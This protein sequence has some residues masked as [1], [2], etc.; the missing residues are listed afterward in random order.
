[1]I[2]E[3]RALCPP[4]SAASRQAAR[5][6]VHEIARP[7]CAV[8]RRGRSGGN[9]F[10]P[11]NNS[12]RKSPCD[13][14]GATSRVI[15]VRFSGVVF[16]RR[17]SRAKRGQTACRSIALKRFRVAACGARLGYHTSNQFS[18]A[19]AAEGTPH[20]GNRIE[21]IR[22]PPSRR[23]GL[24]GCT[25]MILRQDRG[26]G[27]EWSSRMRLAPRLL[28]ATNPWDRSDLLPLETTA[29]V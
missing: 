24:P 20:G 10:R 1:M 23:R 5:V 17:D 11:R 7:R 16:S 3:E 28:M 29:K 14:M 6:G 12:P 21:P 15:V 22:G 13:R 19:R 8:A 18:L 26:R 2:C 27:R 9:G 4:P 25:M